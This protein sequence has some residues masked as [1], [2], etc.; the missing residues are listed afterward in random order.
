MVEKKIRVLH[1]DIGTRPKDLIPW[2]CRV[3]AFSVKYGFMRPPDPVKDA[4]S[5]PVKKKKLEFS[6]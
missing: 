5:Q 3:S 6:F 2:L 4:L 1:C